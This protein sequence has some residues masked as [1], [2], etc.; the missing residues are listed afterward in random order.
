MKI[1]QSNHNEKG[2]IALASVLVIAA[3]VIT[4]GLS[5]SLLSVNEAQMSLSGK[6]SKESV[7]L[8]EGCVEDALMR[9]NTSNTI[10]SQISLPEGTCNVTIDAQS[11]KDWTVT[12]TGTIDTYTKR[13]QATITRNTSVLI[14]TWEEIE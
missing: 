5:T 10:P 3:I 6:K 7:D 12:V 8:V 1:E 9:I 2:Y 11:G 4:I 14:T 13:V